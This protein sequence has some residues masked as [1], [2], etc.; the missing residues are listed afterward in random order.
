[1]SQAKPLY[2]SEKNRVVAGICG[3]LGDYLEI[4]PAIIRLIWIIFVF[5]GGAGFWAYIVAWIIIPEEPEYK[6]KEAKMSGKVKMKKSE[7]EVASEVTQSSEKNKREKKAYWIGL[8][9]VILGAIFLA[10]N[11]LPSLRFDRLW[12]LILVAFG[13]ALLFTSKRT[14]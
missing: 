2:R 1:M 14:K 5:A 9:L 13:V 6:T 8:I 11:F 3:G 10:N 12:P 7:K 4:D